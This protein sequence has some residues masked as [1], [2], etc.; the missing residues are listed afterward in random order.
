MLRLNISAEPE[1]LALAGGAAIIMD[2]PTTAAF[3][4]AQEM[5][6]ARLP[7]RDDKEKEPAYLKRVKPVLKAYGVDAFYGRM[8]RETA[9]R[10][11]FVA[12]LYG[13]LAEVLIR[14]WEGIGDDTGAPV[15]VT[16]P[17]VQAAMRSPLIGPPVRDRIEASIGAVIHEGNASAPPSPTGGE[18]AH[19]T[20]GIAPASAKPA[21]RAGAAR[22]PKTGSSASARKSNTRPKASKASKS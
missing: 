16:I 10:A 3:Y 9:E 5:A 15:P 17:N 4:A 13:C 11:L 8:P 19:K 22:T 18:A 21:A 12:M 2:P 6:R 1:R 20:A 7:G 14:D